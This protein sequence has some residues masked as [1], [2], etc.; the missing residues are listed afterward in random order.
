[1]ELQRK[2]PWKDEADILVSGF[3]L[4]HAIQQGVPSNF[5]GPILKERLKRLT[6]LELVWSSV[7]KG[8]ESG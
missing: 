1:M 6:P 7:N 4:G 8:L 3:D 2:A 5:L